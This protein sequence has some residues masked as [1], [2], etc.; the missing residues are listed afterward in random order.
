MLF[1]VEHSINLIIKSDFYLF[2]FRINNFA[3]Y[4][5]FYYIYKFLEIISSY[6]INFIYKNKQTKKN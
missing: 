5:E 1:S 3:S 4:Y 6:F 2:S